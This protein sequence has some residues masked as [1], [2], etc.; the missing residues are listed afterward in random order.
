MEKPWIVR[1]MW[2]EFKP[3]LFCNM[4]SALRYLPNIL[5]Y[6]PHNAIIMRKP[7]RNQSQE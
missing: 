5:M 6:E 4:N 3:S 7:S 1:K 2:V